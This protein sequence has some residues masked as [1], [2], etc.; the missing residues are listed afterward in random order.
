M[1]RYCTLKGCERKYLAR[2]YCELHYRRMRRHGTLTT[3]RIVDP[4]RHCSVGGC[5]RKHRARGYCGLHYERKREGMADWDT[6]PIRPVGP[7]DGCSVIGCDRPYDSKGLCIFHYAR[8]YI[9]KIPDW[10]TRPIQLKGKHVVCS[11]D[12]CLNPHIA[13]GFCHNH[14]LTLTGKGKE[15]WNRRRVRMLGAGG[16][17]TSDEWNILLDA[18][19]DLCTYC[20]EEPPEGLVAEHVIPLSRGGT[21]SIENILPACKKC[22]SSKGAKTLH[23]WRPDLADWFEQLGYVVE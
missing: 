9:N 10:E 18:Y 5:K 19:D 2:G 7:F 14:W 13:K 3:T 12:G 8:K 20:G 21:N 11:I 23:E 22:N 1:I 6:R 4:D 17:F 15:Y 16:S